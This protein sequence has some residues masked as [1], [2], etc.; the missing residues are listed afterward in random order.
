LR[1]HLAAGGTVEALGERLMTAIAAVVPVLPVPLVAKALGEGAASRDELLAR[2][3]ALVGGLTTVGAVLK[4]PPQGLSAAM[5]EG[6]A[7]LIRR[8]L[9]SKELQPAASERALLRFY[10]ASVPDIGVAAAPQT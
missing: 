2:V 9:V 8:G 7:P 1:E 5:E 4:L 10:A 3:E 6:L